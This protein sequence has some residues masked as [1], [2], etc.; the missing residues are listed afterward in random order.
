MR[1][2]KIL[3]VAISLIINTAPALAIS[4]TATST[5][6]S[7]ESST[8]SV[9]KLTFKTFDADYKLLK[10]DAS[11]MLVEETIVAVFPETDENH[12]I[13]RRIPIYNQGGY[14]EIFVG[15]YTVD[16]TMDGEDINFT[17]TTDNKYATVR[18]GSASEYLHGQHTFVISYKYENVIINTD[19]VLSSPKINSED[20]L[21]QELYWNV[22]GTDWDYSFDRVSATVHLSNKLMNALY[23][24]SDKNGKS[25]AAW[26][27]T[28]KSRSTAQDCTITQN[29]DGY[30][31]TAYNLAARANL[32]ISLGF[33]KDTF[34]V[35]GPS[36]SYI[37]VILGVIEVI[38]V[39]IMGFLTYKN[40]YLKNREKHQY[41]KKLFVTPQ[42]Q[43]LKGYTVG[44]IARCVIEE[45]GTRVSKEHTR[46]ATLLE[47]ITSGKLTLIRGAG[48]KLADG[49][50]TGEVRASGILTYEK[51]EALTSKWKVRISDTSNLSEEQADLIKLIFAEEEIPAVGQE[52]TIKKHVSTLELRAIYESYDE[53]IT[54]TLEARGDLEDSAKDARIF[55]GAKAGL[56]VL[57]V[58]FGFPFAGGLLLM[59][60]FIAAA[61]GGEKLVVG[62]GFVPFLILGLIAF[63]I[64]RRIVKNK[65]NRY[66]DLTI[67][68]LDR[69]NY[70]EG[71]KLYIKMAEQDR[72]KFLQSVDGADVSSEGIVKLY[73][74]LLPYAAIFG[75]EKSWMQELGK[76]YKEL[77]IAEPDWYSSDL[78][79]F[80]TTSALAGSIST[81]D[82]VS[83]PSS[84]G[85]GSDY[86]GGD[87]DSGGGGG[88]GGS[89]GG[90]GGGGGG[91][92][93]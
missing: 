44:Q 53:H 67:Q 48:N 77:N 43:P 81:I 51:L 73:E 28:G 86:F 74:K 24:T 18:I 58:V 14:N 91:G 57:M 27:Y 68:G 63:F 90:G 30:T 59:L 9:S 20:V 4:E 15:A 42:Y 26:C 49:L 45:K 78:Y 70:M 32:T 47:L 25:S 3:F 71:L 41:Y 80:T 21:W 39:G 35:P 50:E 69:A 72:I 23:T 93:W 22:N 52:T 17:T 75:C 29:S 66:R 46:T 60:L 83:L 37:V 10:D 62:K 89:S 55:T 34:V 64:I 92:G 38:V 76:Y 5:N 19:G 36:K 16:V 33:N 1:I 6:T 12:G 8:T 2:I 31:I 65:F 54:E 11:T 13:E 56:L 85:S 40:I 88:G 7:E 79:T 61:D 82:S 84:S 87:G